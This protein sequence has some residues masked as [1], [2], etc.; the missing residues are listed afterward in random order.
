MGQPRPLFGLFKQTSI[1]FWQQINVKKWHIRPV[2]GI[3]THNLSIMS[4]Q[5]LPLDQGSRPRR[6]VFHGELMFCFKS[7]NQ[8]SAID[9][10]FTH[11]KYYLFHCHTTS[12]LLHSLYLSFSYI[13]QSLSL[14]WWHTHAISCFMFLLAITKHRMRNTST[15][16]AAWQHND[17]LS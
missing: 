1:Q 6:F 10:S 4:H 2:A 13:P 9:A 5:P 17:S 3:R 16:P 11:I 14:Y 15:E 12:P 8:S 7:C